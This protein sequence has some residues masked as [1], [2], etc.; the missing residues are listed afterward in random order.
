[1]IRNYLIVA[2]ILAASLPVKLYA[3]NGDMTMWYNRP[4]YYWLEAM[5]VGNGHI[6]GMVYGK[7]ST[8][9]IQLNEETVSNGS[10]YS[11]YN[12]DALANL[13]S[14]RQMIW[15]KQYTKAQDFVTNHFL[16]TNG[17]GEQYQYVGEL[18]IIN[19]DTTFASYRRGLDM[20]NGIAFTEYTRDGVTY[21]REVFASIPDNMMIVRLTANKA[22]ALSMNVGLWTPAS[23]Y[24]SRSISG[25]IIYLN[26]STRQRSQ[27]SGKTQL[28]F[29][30]RVKVVNVGGTISKGDTTLNI[31]GADTVTI[32][33]AM[34]TNFKSYKEL[35]GNAG[36]KCGAI[37]NA[38]TKN[39]N[40]ALEQHKAAFNEYMDR[41]SL[42]LGDNMN[43]DMPTDERLKNF[44][45]NPDP[46]LVALYYQFGRYLLVSCS[47]PG[48]QPANLQ[49][50]WN[51]SL[52]PAWKC[53]YTTNINTEMNYWPAETTALPEMAGPLFDMINDLTVIGN[54][55]A[56]NMY[57]CRGWMLHHNTDLWRMTGAV[58]KAYSGM[59]PTCNAWL[60]QHLWEHYLFSGDKSFLSQW[61]P[62]LK[63]ACQFFIDFMVKDPN[64]GYMVVCPGVSPENAPSAIAD[65]PHVFGG[66]TMDNEL[67][68][69]LFFITKQAASTLGVDEMFC[70]TIQNLA[71]QMPPLH[72]GQ[73]GQLQEW[74]E[75]WDNPNDHHRHVSHLWAL[76]PGN[77][78]SPLR[79]P[80][81]FSGA[82]TSLIERGDA[83]TG[84]SMGWKVCLWARCLDGNHAYN[85]IKDQLNLVNPTITSGQ[86]GGTYPNFFDAHPPFQIDGN[87]GCT[88]GISEMLLQSQDGAVHLLPAIPDAWKNGEVKGLR[89][90]GG[91]IV[92]NM[93]WNE[94][95]IV[96]VT[97]R[98]IIGGNLRL[99][100]VTPLRGDT[101]LAAATGTNKN[102]LF[103]TPTILTPIIKDV[104]KLASVSLPS[105]Y[106]YD[107]PTEA[108]ASYTFYATS[109]PAS[110]SA[111]RTDNNAVKA[112]RYFTIDGKYIN[113]PLANN[114]A[115]KR[116]TYNNGCS[117]GEK[118]RY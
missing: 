35:S 96:S 80:N 92:E 33:V 112:I 88:A 71:K 26:G 46:S 25:N 36:T 99:R 111:Q 67:V 59:W 19:N 53:R 38:S 41:V 39:F 75:D 63:S 54:E 103:V 110:I 34:A 70:D 98:S 87:F 93:T 32:Y 68:S 48:C 17:M 30:S 10:P 84:W 15:S 76:F 94:G 9:I 91:F 2:V 95:K 100:S 28:N 89:A 104:S 74:L 113:Q 62:A 27:N 44:V 5:P 72:I 102:P 1:M 64:S 6:A 105:Y 86:G 43:P 49:G 4:A 45:S 40:T 81:V 61:Y 73:Y 90:R 115:I 69:N 107:I 7:T 79:T 18:H 22:N 109:A 85:L 8:E 23:Q 101:A 47:Q 42:H 24:K 116:T 82:R 11:N 13:Q 97:I 29:S 21:R 12:T 114:V 65:K 58:D 37:L 117:K 55:T 3:D 14:L 51:C 106:E 77:E 60:C 66:I 16:S 118:I 20:E 50:K 83:S 57:G 52:N 108:G 31:S 56:R 78:I